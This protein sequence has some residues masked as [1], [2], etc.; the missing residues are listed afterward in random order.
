MKSQQTPYPT[1][2]RL[3]ETT[4]KSFFDDYWQKKPLLVKGLFPGFCS[5][6]TAEEIA[7]LSLEDEV[8]SRLVQEDPTHDNW[9]VLHGPLQESQFSNLPESHWSLL[10]EQADNLIPEVNALLNAF[11]FMPNWR[12]DDIMVSYAPDQGGVGPHFDYYDVFLLQGEGQRRWKIGQTC[13]ADTKLVAN[14]PMKLLAEFETQQEFIVEAG[15]LLYIPAKVAHWGKAIGDSITYSIGFRAPSY[16]E[17]LLDLTQDIAHSLKEDQRYQD[18]FLKPNAHNGEIDASAI[19]R[20]QSILSDL[21]QDKEKIGNW[22]AAYATQQRN[23]ESTDFNAHCTRP[24][25]AQPIRLSPF[26]RCAYMHTSVKQEVTCFVDGDP[27]VCSLDLAQQLSS[28]RYFQAN[29][30]PNRQDR[31]TLANLNQRNLIETRCV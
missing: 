11:R 27:Y 7:G 16:S 13:S 10:V 12:L 14:Q 17:I 30:F 23:A 1:L 20:I 19:E 31:E 8:V 2:K 29:E 6:L 24:P 21:I 3:G 5:P 25:N 28:Y 22:L 4:I 18:S 26:S 15:D 9:T